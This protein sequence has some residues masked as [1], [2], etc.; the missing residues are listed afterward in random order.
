MN[1]YKELLKWYD[2]DYCIEQVSKTT[3]NFRFCKVQPEWL[4]LKVIRKVPD[5]IVHAINPSEKVKL[6]AV[7]FD[8]KCIKYIHN[9][10]EEIQLAAIR[11]NGMMIIYVYN[12]SEKIK[13]EA[14]KNDAF[15][16]QYINNPS[17]EMQLIAVKQS[18]DVI[19]YIDIKKYPEVYEFWKLTWL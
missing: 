15:A 10:S 18:K 16:I 5:Y 1:T 3:W 19:K 13:L 4:Q 8:H 6:E 12:P 7:K 9:P 14:V 17:V 2:L 11:Q